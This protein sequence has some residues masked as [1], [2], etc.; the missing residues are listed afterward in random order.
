VQ[1]P[2]PSQV[3]GEPGNVTAAQADADAAAQLGV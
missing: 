1:S 2:A 3:F